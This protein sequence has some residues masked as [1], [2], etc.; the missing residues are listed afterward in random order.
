MTSTT[1]LLP[2]SERTERAHIEEM[3]VNSPAGMAERRSAPQARRV[4][5]V[6]AALAARRAEQAA[7][8]RRRLWLTVALLVVTAVAWVAVGVAD[9]QVLLAAF[10]TAVLVAVLWLGIRAAKVE[11]EEWAQ[12]PESLRAPRSAAPASQTFSPSQLRDHL[13]SG[14]VRDGEERGLRWST[15]SMRDSAPEE[16]VAPKAQAEPAPGTWTPVPVPVPTYT[17]KATAVRR[18]VADVAGPGV[19]EVAAPAGADAP[20][21]PGIDLNAV[22]ERRRAK[23]A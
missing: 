21:Q 6:R 23:S 10:P 18:E 7:A 8:A 4:A 15:E 9:F 19:A 3:A 1:A 14:G 16:A 22:L 2:N 13:A 12:V 20:E 5:A 11:R 17:L